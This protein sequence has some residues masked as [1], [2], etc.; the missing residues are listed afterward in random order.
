[1]LNRLIFISLI[2]NVCHFS[3]T[4]SEEALD[5]LFICAKECISACPEELRNENLG[6]PCLS[7]CYKDCRHLEKEEQAL[8]NELPAFFCTNGKDPKKVGIKE[9]HMAF[10]QGP[11]SPVALVPGVMATKLKVKIDCKVLKEKEP[12]IFQTCGWNS[13]ENTGFWSKIPSKEYVA[14]IPSLTSPLSIFSIS[15]QSNLCFALLVKPRFDFLKPIQTMNR[16]TPGVTLHVFGFT[17][18]SKKLNRCGADAISNI[19]DMPFQTQDTKGYFK[20]IKQLEFLG[21]VTGI[22]YQ[23]FPYNFF[24]SYRNNE[25]QENFAPNLRRIRQVNGKRVV[26]V[27]H[28][29]GNLNVLYALSKISP[30]EKSEIIFNWVSIT[31]P[32][33]GSFKANKILLSGNDEFSTMGGYLKFHFRAA[34]AS[35]SSQLSTYELGIVNPFDF[36]KGEPWLDKIYK[37]IK[38]EKEYPKIPYEK[39]GILFWPSMDI[40]CHEPQITG[41]P[42]SCVTGLFDIGEEPVFTMDDKPFYVSEFSK[43]YFNYNLTAHTL[44]LYEKMTSKELSYINPGVPVIVICSG[45]IPTG[46]AWTFGKDFK[47]N[48]INEIFPEPIS[49]K[50]AL[51]DETVPMVSMLFLPLKWA[52]MHEAGD[53]SYFPVKFVEYCSLYKTNVNIYDI[54]NRNEEYRIIKNDY[55]GMKCECME[56]KKKTYKDCHH[57]SVHAD[58]Y[59][60]DVVIEALMG[61]QKVSEFELVYIS[62]IS[63]QELVM[64]SEE[65]LFFDPDIYD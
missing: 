3:D 13:C 49:K 12:G 43:L 6:Q 36:F 29:M 31:A 51:G 40:T 23:A 57:S 1:M 24:L 38:Y 54:M 44:P 64:M 45:I 20:L 56:K 7:K 60:I 30:K 2:A 50:E 27:A 9:A 65:C 63:V 58:K 32:L 52:L 46:R 16:K 35:I 26:I 55:I 25:M 4:S 18:E 21:Y 41:V 14:W 33:I 61:N 62:T 19:L 8:L 48:I 11:C 28:S 10:V 22:H 42:S 39:S 53:S 34:V 37:R 59:T 17:N 15:L 5:P 47:Q